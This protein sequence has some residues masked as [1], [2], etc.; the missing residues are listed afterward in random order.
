M[1]TGTGT[2]TGDKGDGDGEG[3]GEENGA[4]CAKQNSWLTWFVCAF[5][6]PFMA[7]F[8]SFPIQLTWIA[9]R[10]AVMKQ[11]ETV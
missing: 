5:Y 10:V 4:T 7:S 3:D 1:V 2:E 9:G 11:K 6:L 8:S